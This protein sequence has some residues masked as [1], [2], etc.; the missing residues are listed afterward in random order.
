MTS[1]SNPTYFQ[2]TCCNYLRY[3]PRNLGEVL[4]QV[5]VEEWEPSVWYGTSI[6]CP[7]KSC[8]AVFAPIGV[9]ASY[10]RHLIE[11]HNI[12]H[13]WYRDTR[14]K[15]LK[16]LSNIVFLPPIESIEMTGKNGTSMFIEFKK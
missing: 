2:D 1:E 7:F 9:Y 8:N 10:H 3:I 16:K 15:D 4:P 6:K 12:C 11:V 13:F 14:G 5:N